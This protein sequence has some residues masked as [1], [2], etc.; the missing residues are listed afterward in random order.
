MDR[1]D[2]MSMLVAV[3]EAGS[4][5]AA[6]RRLDTPLTTVSRKISVLEEHLKT[7]LLT[8]SSR[9][10][11]LTD[12]GKSYVA[13]CKRILEDVSEAERTAA[14]EYTAPKGDLSITSPIVFGRLH[15][16]PVL[17]DFLRAYPDID[18]RLTLSNRQ[19]S[20]TEEGIDAALR[21]GNLPD[22]RMIATRVGT[23]SRVFA[24]SP[25]YLQIRGVPLTPGDLVGHDCIGVEGFT[26]SGFW[27]LADG[28][29]IPVRYRLIV[30]STDAACEAAKEGMGIVSV[31]SHHVAQDFRDGTLISV[32]PDFKRETLPIS[33]VRESGEYLPLKLRA[34][35]DFFT[36]RLKARLSER[37]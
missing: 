10:I 13:A 28:V 25:G 1:L 14:G 7:Q 26:G 11:S 15:L 18:V 23:V 31:F 33:L 29:E 20:L 16:V 27:S 34:F 9:S 2:S 30:N 12:A 17:A 4:L 24:A 8:R 19:V 21:V 6:A 37:A 5:S 3:S 35:L 32:L 36:P 22:S